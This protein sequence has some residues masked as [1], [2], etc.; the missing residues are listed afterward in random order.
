MQLKA[1]QAHL[2]QHPEIKYVYY[3]Y[4]CLPQG[5]QT[6]EERNDFRRMLSEMRMLYLGA[7]VLLLVD[8]SCLSRFWTQLEAWLSLQMCTPDGLAPASA[9]ARRCTIV[10]IYNANDYIKDALVDTCMWS[11]K[12]PAEAYDILARPDVMVTNMSDKDAQLPRIS[13][14]MIV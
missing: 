6:E 12:T 10:P 1:I 2:D 7:S 13:R 3:D 9:E 4:S 14:W 8:L 5:E 11:S